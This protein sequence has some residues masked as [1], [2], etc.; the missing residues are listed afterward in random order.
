MAD[1]N[2]YILPFD[3][4]EL[5]NLKKMECIE[6]DM[7]KTEFPEN[8]NNISTTFVYLR[9]I[10][11]T[12]IKLNFSKCD[13]DTKAKYLKEYI[14]TKFEIKQKE[15]SDTLIKVVCEYY[16]GIKETIESY[17]FLNTI[18]IDKFINENLETVKTI[19]NF[20]VSLPLYQ[21][22]RLELEED[23]T[24]DMTGINS[25]DTE[26]MGAN[27]YNFLEDN[28][29]IVG[30]V[31]AVNP[32]M[33]TPNIYTKYFTKDNERLIYVLKDSITNTLLYCIANHQTELFNNIYEISKEM[34][35]INE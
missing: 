29:D 2:L 33:D 12:N 1:N 14:S 16:K 5:E 21:I 30:Y 23:T 34:G 10:G 25:V 32:N 4:M 28:I 17:S 19:S 20:L 27:L 7:S 31:F 13:Y 6:I 15:F 9:N 35:A 22:M 8:I 24:L 18:E 11:L 3:I 26:V